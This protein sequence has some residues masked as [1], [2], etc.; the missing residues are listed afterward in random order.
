MRGDFVDTTIRMNTHFWLAINVRSV[1]K[2]L[3]S[4]LT[5]A[6]V[7][8]YRIMCQYVKILCVPLKMGRINITYFRSYA[9]AIQR[10][11]GYAN[12]SPTFAGW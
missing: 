8:M 10:S 5:P 3:L 11:N 7:L 2:G 4:V 9:V 1:C 12:P 6:P